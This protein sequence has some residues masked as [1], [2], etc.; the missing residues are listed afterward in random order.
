MNGVNGGQGNLVLSTGDMVIVPDSMVS[1]TGE[2]KKPGVYPI[3]RELTVLQLISLAEGFTDIA[4]PNNVKVVH[5]NS[6]GTKEE[7]VVHAYS[8][9]NGTNGDQDK[10]ALSI[11]DMVIVPDS[12]VS[13]T[14]EVTKP[15]RYPI[16]GSLTV[17]ELI[18]LAGGFTKIAA[19]NSIKVIHIK[20]DGTKEEKV[21]RA[22]D[23]ANIKDGKKNEVTLS[24][25]D[26][27][28]VPESLF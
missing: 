11:G 20:P 24:V 23:Y 19:P 21:V 16:K 6:D 13:I 28:I 2:V 26:D 12:M 22:Y 15:G 8:D 1:I 3:K 17:L 9:M 5:T 27:V 10:V 14:G 25:G 18:S 4:A 7:R